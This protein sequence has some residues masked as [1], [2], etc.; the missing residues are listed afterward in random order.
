MHIF[1]C[2]DDD[3]GGLDVI[4]VADRFYHKVED[5][6]PRTDGVG[7]E[8]FFHFRCQNSSSHGMLGCTALCVLARFV[9]GLDRVRGDYKLWAKL[10]LLVI[11]SGGGAHCSHLRAHLLL[12][13]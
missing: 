1:G 2:P 7:N 10:K 5:P 3:I 6:R 12:V 13:R 8:K 9:G 4:F 11:I